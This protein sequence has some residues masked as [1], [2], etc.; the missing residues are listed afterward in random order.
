MWG[1]NESVWFAMFMGVALKSTA[2]LGAA[3]VAAGLAAL[4]NA[5]LGRR[6]SD[7]VSPNARELRANLATEARS[8]ALAGSSS[9]RRIGAGAGN[10][11]CRGRAGNGWSGH[12]DD[13]RIPAPG[14]LP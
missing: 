2:V 5:S 9:L 3:W 13:V 10:P 8:Q 11:G 7:W 4:A 12:A 1:W 6:R 14:G